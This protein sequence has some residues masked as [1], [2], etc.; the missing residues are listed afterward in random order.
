MLFEVNAKANKLDEERS[1]IFH[2]IVAK[3]LYLCKRTRPDI[4]TAVAFLCTRVKGPDVDN[5]KKLNRCLAYLK[6]NKDIILT[7]EAASMDMIKWWVDASYAVHPDCRSHTGATV[8]VGKG[9]FYSM[10]SKQKINTR[11]STEA[12]LVGVNDAMSMIIWMRL[13]LEAQGFDV[14]DNVVFQ[15]NMSSILLEKNGR[16]SSGKQTRHIEIRYYFITDN[17][18]RGRASVI[19]CPTEDMVADFFTKPLQGSLFRKFRSIIMNVVDEQ[20]SGAQECVVTSS[21]SRGNPADGQVEEE[22]PLTAVHG[23]A[24]VQRTWAEVASSGSSR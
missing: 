18:R 4:Q 14:Q 11:S 2:H 13:F 19:H 22:C 15:D 24:A 1:E 8:S 16:R 9:S 23:K 5:W 6:N 10:S 12:E 17:I 21:G 7:L 3:L 20:L